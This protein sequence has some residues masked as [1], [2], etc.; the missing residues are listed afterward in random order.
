MKKL[1]Q[2]RSRFSYADIRR[3]AETEMASLRV[4]RDIRSQIQSHGLRGVQENHYDM[5]EYIE[6]KIEVLTMW[7]EHLTACGE[8]ARLHSLAA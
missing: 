7:Y 3:T 8:K 4:S 2:V 1:N 5:W 6:Q